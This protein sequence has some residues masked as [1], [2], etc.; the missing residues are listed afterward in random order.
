MA[1]RNFSV[2]ELSRLIPTAH[3]HGMKVYV[4]FNTMLRP[5]ELDRAGGLI[6][7]LARHACP[8]A[9]IVQDLAL[10]SLTKQGGFKGEIH[11]STLANASFPRALEAIG[12]GLGITRIVLPREL[13]IDEIKRMAVA[14]PPGI[15]LE[16]FVHGALCYAVSGRCYW[17][18]Y[19]GGRSGLRGRCVQP[20]RRFYSQGGQSRR[21]FSCQ[22]L[23]LDVLVKVL[24]EVDRVRGWKIEGRKKSPHYVYHTVK[25]YRMLRDFGSDPVTRAD[26][27][28][29]ALA[30]L[31]AALGRSANHFRFLPQRPWHP[32]QTTAQTGSGLML[33]TL[34]GPLSAPY[35]LPRQDLFAG[36]LIRVG[37][38]DDPGHRT[39][40]IRRFVPARGRFN[41]SRS[42]RRPAGRD[43]PVFLIDRRGKDLAGDLQRLT[44]ELQDTA[45]ARIAKAPFRAHLPRR[46]ALSRQAASDQYVHRTPARQ[47]TDGNSG[48]WLSKD[49]LSQVPAA[50]A[51]SVWWWIPPVIWPE[52]EGQIEALLAAVRSKGGRRFVI[53]APWQASFF[54]RRRGLT[55]WAGPFC[56]LANPLALEA[57][58]ELGAA[59]AMVSPELGKDDILQLPAISPLPLGIVLAGAWPLCISRILAEDA[60]TETLFQSPKKE[61]AWVRRHG[62]DYWVYPDWQIDLTTKKRELTR[63]G[64]RLFVHLVETFPKGIRPNERPGLWNW[65]LELK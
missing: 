21:Y 58:A 43:V 18:S 47:L 38:E 62:V 4:A 59:G 19:M 8:D 63:A 40:R 26:V 33:G 60:E 23:S 31:A 61:G 11:L 35:L 65:S 39:I 13:S 15:G 55:L 29:E 49:A 14:C 53:N 20:C 41:L 7:D 32:I 52:N 12:S 56:N 5:G 3:G 2:E 10:V 6:R 30:L 9:L 22:D 16:V 28:K 48:I 17:S 1:A 37:Y 25:A 51:A 36:D 34:Q 45:C 57:V 44:R 64:Y 54:G 24:G 42:S 46:A 50:A 27:K